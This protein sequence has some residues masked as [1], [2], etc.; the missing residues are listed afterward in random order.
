MRSALFAG[1]FAFFAEE[2]IALPLNHMTFGTAVL[3]YEGPSVVLYMPMHSELLPLTRE[4]E[5]KLQYTKLAFEESARH[6]PSIRYGEFDLRECE[7]SSQRVSDLFSHYA[8][9]HDLV[10]FPTIV[11]YKKGTASFTGM[12]RELLRVEK[13]VG[14]RKDIASFVRALD[15][16]V[17]E[18]LVQDNPFYFTVA[19]DGHLYPVVKDSN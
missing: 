8:L 5:N 12:R 3:E 18:D 13:G 17:E 10:G 4:K 15:F 9:A 11:L 6:F 19:E 7:Y 1:L 2:N 16:L 14:S